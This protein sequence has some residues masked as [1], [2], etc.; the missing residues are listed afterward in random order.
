M[1]DHDDK[2]AEV[3]RLYRVGDFRAARARCREILSSDA[4]A[5]VRDRVDEI[6]AATGIDPA[7][8][9][10]FSLSIVVLIYLI[11]HYLL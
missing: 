10:A 11:V 6:L 7:A 8:I 1:T 4:P 3:E 2:L 5:H 9:A